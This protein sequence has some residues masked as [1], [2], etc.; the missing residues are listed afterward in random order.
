MAHQIY[1]GYDPS[2]QIARMTG[3]NHAAA[4]KRYS[5]ALES[6]GKMLREALG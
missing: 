6:L 4:R 2:Q 5:R 1:I 3:I